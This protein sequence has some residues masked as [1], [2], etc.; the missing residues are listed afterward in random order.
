MRKTLSAAITILCLAMVAS[1]GDLVKNGSFETPACLVTPSNCFANSGD[2]GLDWTVEWAETV[3]STSPANSLGILEIWR[4]TV[5][6]GV[7]PDSGVQNV[8]LDTHY[9]PGGFQNANVRIYQSIATCPGANYSL[10][11]SWRPRP[12]LPTSS[13]GVTVKWGESTVA[14]HNGANL[15][16]QDQTTTVAGA[17]GLQK[18]M[19]IGGGTGDQ[20]GTLLDGVSLNGPDPSDSNACTTVNIK[21][22]SN[23]NSINVCSSGSVPVT[24]WG[25]ATF[26]VNTIDP[27][28]LLLGG[29]AVRIPGKSGRYQCSISDSG[30]PNSSL[31]DGIGAPD[32]HPDL[33]CQFTT[34]PNMFAAE[35]VTATVDMTVC[36]D[37]FALGCEG[38]ASTPITAHDAVRIVKEG[39]E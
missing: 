38:K 2:Q 6:A 26:H 15:P 29:A 17:F 11:Y 13:Q 18:L 8:E 33:T 28:L 34:E 7:Y 12:N 39:C 4:G 5:V 32:G 24:I 16:W 37:G 19:F 25:S 9:R 20:N 22:F 27:S 31:F 36:A 10:A 23:P 14:T 21:P 35:A 30:S 1:A 3:S